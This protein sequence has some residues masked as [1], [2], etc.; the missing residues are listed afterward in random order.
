[1]PPATSNKDRSTADSNRSSP[2]PGTVLRPNTRRNGPTALIEDH[3]DIKDALEGRKFLEKHSL[4]CPPGEPATHSSL[5]TC[6]HQVSILPGVSKQA[7]NAIR[8]VAFLLEEMEE[9]QIHETIREAIDIQM[10][11]MTTDMKS[12]IEDAKEKI[13]EQCR[14]AEERLANIQ[15]QPPPPPPLP[16]TRTTNTYASALVNPPA[17]ANPRV[18]AR[19]GIKARQFM[20]EGIRNSKFSHLDS[21]QLKAE[22]NKILADLGPPSGRLRSVN[23][24]RSGG[25][26]VEADS[27]EAANWLADKE[28]QR[29]FCDS[30]GSNTE[31][32]TR[33]YSTIAFNV[34]TAIDPTKDDHRLEICEANN[35]DPTNIIAI[36]WAKAIER[37]SPAQRTA[38]LF[39][40]FDNADA[41]N[42]SITNGMTICNRRC[43]VERTKHEPIRCMKCQGWNHFAKDCIEEKDTCGN[44]AGQHRTTSCLSAE[45]NCASCKSG[46]HASWS[47]ACPTFLK[48]LAEYNFRNP[49]NSL[50]YFPTADPW[51]WT[52]TEM[53]PVTHTHTHAQTPSLPKQSQ[54]RP[55]KIQLE[56]RPQ[57]PLRR[58]YDTYIPSYNN[59]NSNNNNNYNRYASLDYTG[60]SDTAGWG[61]VAGPSTTRPP[62]P[63][64][65]PPPPP[66]SNPS[67]SSPVLPTPPAQQ[68]EST[69]ED[70][71]RPT[72]TSTSTRTD[73]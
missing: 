33:A 44:C 12:L 3:Q 57:Q 25:L 73:A 35:L 18:A 70:D 63:P 34:P 39:V 9:I 15:Q 52:A 46:D 42:R 71:N 66:P 10:T 24:S 47:R 61:E 36:K 11:E 56:K 26:V 21:P 62:P 68:A 55:S 60:H 67:P 54:P 53:R 17:H 41:A 31:F 48:K 30:I 29:N 4:I 14:A 45:K 65:L 43:Q 38:H 23:S 58:K 72:N 49:E 64:P 27:D 13:N 5:S 2:N 37:R 40:T 28:N 8:S 16:Q 50:Q 69:N 19:E 32:R 59:N 20:L 6:L 51:S 7:I 1:M 22:L